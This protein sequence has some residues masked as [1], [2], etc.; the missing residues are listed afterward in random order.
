MRHI[1]EFNQLFENTQEL[2]QEQMDWLDVCVSGTW[3]INPQTGL[4]NIEG[5]FDYDTDAPNFNGVRFGDIGG[6]FR[7]SR[8]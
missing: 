4:V 1:K 8:T 7:C 6:D 5:D 2:T 3:Q